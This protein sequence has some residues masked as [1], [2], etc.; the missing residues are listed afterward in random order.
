VLRQSRIL[1]EHQGLKSDGRDFSTYDTS[2][3]GNG[4]SGDVHGTTLSDAD[5]AAPVEH[6]KTC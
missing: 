3:P 4:N 6:L 1:D 2:V 5:K